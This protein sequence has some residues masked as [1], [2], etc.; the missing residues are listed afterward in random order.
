MLVLM[1]KKILILVE[2]DF[3]DMEAMY[4]YYRLKEAGFDV[5]VAGSD[6]KVYN[7]KH[8][9]P[10]EADGKI[11]EFKAEDF[12]A[13]IIPGGWAPDY[14][15]RNK[16][17]VDFVREMNEKGKVVAAICHAASLLVSA[18]VLKGKKMTCFVA[19]KDDAINAGADFV[20]EEVVV[21]GNLITSRTPDDLPAFCRE[22]IKALS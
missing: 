10:I 4:P 9:Y 11:E 15:R 19:V 5:K 21:D 7:G 16:A 14:M 1:T 3:Q 12:A 8:G 6:A 17:M 2:Q 13:V 20:D 18:D 22:I